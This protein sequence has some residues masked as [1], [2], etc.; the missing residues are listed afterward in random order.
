MSF[1]TGNFKVVDVSEEELH[2][3]VPPAKL[4]STRST[5]PQVVLFLALIAFAAMLSITLYSYFQS[6]SLVAKQEDLQKSLVISLERAVQL[7]KEN[8]LL[9]LSNEN[10]RTSLNT[11][12]SNYTS[13]KANALRCQGY[14]GK[15]VLELKRVRETNHSLG[16]V[17]IAYDQQPLWT[18]VK[19]SAK[20]NYEAVQG[21]FK[22]SSTSTDTVKVIG[23]G[24]P[25][26]NKWSEAVSAE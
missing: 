14:V 13:M 23:S 6:Q 1:E 11:A 5:S 12:N 10:L 9:R 26:L 15:Q 22:A 21:W 7:E 20:L 25:T 2:R 8:N 18:T 19:R 17:V 4:G 3:E 24:M 16:E